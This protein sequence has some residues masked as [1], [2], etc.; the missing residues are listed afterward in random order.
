MVDNDGMIVLWYQIQY[1][2]QIKYL[3]DL[4]ILMSDYDIILLIIL[5]M[6]EIKVDFF[7]WMINYNMTVSIFAILG[8]SNGF[9]LLIFY[10]FIVWVCK[11]IQECNLRHTQI[12]Q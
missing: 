12:K 8:T 11:W 9:F 2:K 1:P 7:V 10:F 3:M 6:N 4:F 5:K